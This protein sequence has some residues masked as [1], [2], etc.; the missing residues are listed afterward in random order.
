QHNIS[1]H[2]THGRRMV[3]LLHEAVK[4]TQTTRME[5]FMS[6]QTIFSK[7]GNWFRKGQRDGDLPLTGEVDQTSIEP[8]STFLR[9]WARRDA[10]VQH[11]QEGFLTL[12]D[13]MSTI[14]TN[15]ENQSK[16]Q[17]ELVNCLAHLPEALRSIPESSRIHGETLRAIHQQL[18]QQNV[19]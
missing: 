6:Q 12:T 11:L 18:E 10:A 5:A 14:K 3:K 13:L 7:L 8:R 15:L 19:Q 17:D 1:E 2:L 9:P 16:R 4:P